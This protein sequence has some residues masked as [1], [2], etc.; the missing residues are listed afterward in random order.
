MNSPLTDAEIEAMINRALLA[1]KTVFGDQ[2]AALKASGPYSTTPRVPSSTGGTLK[3][4]DVVGSTSFNV[5][6]HS[7]FE[8]ENS[9][10]TILTK[11]ER[12]RLSPS[13]KSKIQATFLKGISERSFTSGPVLLCPAISRT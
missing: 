6:A 9:S 4:S 7:E 5:T 3:V 2:I 1:Q 10:L 12:A 11:A 13:D 8:I